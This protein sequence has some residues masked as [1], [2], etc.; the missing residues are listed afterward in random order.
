MKDIE[1]RCVIVEAGAQDGL[2]TVDS[3]IKLC[4]VEINTLRTQ[5]EDLAGDLKKKI[6]NTHA[7]VKK[8]DAK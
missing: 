3:K 1:R 4:D 2:K 8:S 5:V 7:F 6:N